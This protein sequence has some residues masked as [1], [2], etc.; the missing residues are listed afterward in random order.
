M[1]ATSAAAVKGNEG[2]ATA[3]V[4]M[5]VGCFATQNNGSEV[6]Q[7]MIDTERLPWQDAEFCSKLIQVGFKGVVY[8]SEKAKAAIGLKQGEPVTTEMFVAGIKATTFRGD[9]KPNKDDETE[10]A[11]ILRSVEA[12]NF[13][14]AQAVEGI[15]ASYGWEVTPDLAGFVQHC[16]RKRMKLEA[17]KAETLD[18]ADLL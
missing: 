15:K 14:A 2:T 1:K 8:R 3:V 18:L 11:R 5:I 16:F 12:G 13:T 7:G 6:Y 10:A 17:E 9:A 4:A